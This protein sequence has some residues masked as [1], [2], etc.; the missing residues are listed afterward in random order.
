[1][2]TP[3]RTSIDDHADLRRPAT[4]GD[5]QGSHA[6]SHSGYRAVRFHLGDECV[7]GGKL[8]DWMIRDIASGIEQRR[9]QQ[10]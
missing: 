7:G 2:R 6:L 9:I 10:V 8:D 5:D 1:M 3:T 4:G